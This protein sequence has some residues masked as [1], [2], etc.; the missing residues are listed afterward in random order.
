[1]VP[2]DTLLIG[3]TDQIAVA[4]NGPRPDHDSEPAGPVLYLATP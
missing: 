2:I 4:V 1:M 3:L